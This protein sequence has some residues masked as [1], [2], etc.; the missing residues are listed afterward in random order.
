[1]DAIE[2][3]AAAP[4]RISVHREP[5]RL[6]I[7]L[8]GELDLS[9]VTALDEA[10]GREFQD[11]PEQLVFDLSELAFMD[12][13]GIAALLRARS[14]AGAVTLRKPSDIVRR[15]IVGTGL[16]EILPMES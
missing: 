8:E 4:L 2:G 13:S 3:D 7:T 15:V 10:L 5:S 14:L 16:T 9:N 1:M 12:S 11:S 6:V